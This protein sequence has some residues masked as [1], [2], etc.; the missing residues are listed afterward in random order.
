[1]VVSI[2][3]DHIVMYYI[4]VFFTMMLKNNVIS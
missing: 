4:G 3:L 2:Q 1:M